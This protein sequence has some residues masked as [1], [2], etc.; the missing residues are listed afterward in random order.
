[1]A[2]EK[3]YI[4]TGRLCN[5]HSELEENEMVIR[6]DYWKPLRRVLRYWLNDELKLEI[7]MKVFRYLRS[8]SQNNYYWGVVIPT[9]RA[10]HKEQ[11]GDKLSPEQVHAFNLIHIMGDEPKIQEVKGRQVVTLS[12]KSSSKMNTKE[13]SD[14][15]EKIQAFYDEKG[16]YIPNPKPKTNNTLTDFIDVEDN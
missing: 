4:I 6:L 11:T 12:I 15:V 5:K 1:M 2:E 13:F 9:I 14:F 10:W 3:E 7:T 8:V 16:C